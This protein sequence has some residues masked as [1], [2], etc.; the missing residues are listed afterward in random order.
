MKAQTAKRSIV[1]L[2]LLAFVP[3]LGFAQVAEHSWENLQQLRVG[4]RI[5]VVER[6]VKTHN[7]TFLSYSED[8]ISLRVGNDNIGIQRENVVRVSDRE[9]SKRG[10]NAVI[11][12][13]AGAALGA[14]VGWSAG[15][16]SGR[17]GDRGKITAGTAIGLGVVGAAIGASVPSNPTIYRA[18]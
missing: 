1:I 11:G 3:A 10:R 5:R 14:A 13:V 17:V 6:N 4:Q 15:G 9:Q 7:G 16:N 12:A 2:V 8:A 18:P